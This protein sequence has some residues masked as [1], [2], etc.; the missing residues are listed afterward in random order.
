M[1]KT[2]LAQ[3]QRE[4]DEALAR[5]EAFKRAK[6]ESAKVEQEMSAAEQALKFVTA[7]VAQR[8]GVPEHGP[9]ALTSAAVRGTPE[10]QAAK[11]RVDNA[12]KRLRAFNAVFAREFAKE[13]RTERADR[14]RQREG[15]SGSR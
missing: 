7:A 2:P 13:L 5:R 12:F 1:P 6:I 8:L 10:W 3:L 15:R 9:M 14:T 11:V 4:I